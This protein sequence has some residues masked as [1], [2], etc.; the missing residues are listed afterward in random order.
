MDSLV[1]KEST[2]CLSIMNYIVNLSEAET[3]FPQGW[4]LKII[5]QHI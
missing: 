3:L 4:Q 1:M 5:P 2:D